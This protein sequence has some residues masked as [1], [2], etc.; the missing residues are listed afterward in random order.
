MIEDKLYGDKPEVRYYS[1]STANMVIIPYDITV[2]DNDYYSWRE[3]DIKTKYFSYD[4]IVNLLICR[5]YPSDKMQAII[6]NY[7]LDPTD[8]TALSEFNEMQEFRKTVKSIARQ[9]MDNKEKGI[10]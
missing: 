2:H 8:E 4:G 3:L 10:I 1:T 7:L 6:N 9:I 5:K